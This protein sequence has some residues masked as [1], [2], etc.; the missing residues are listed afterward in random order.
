MT[1]R[2]RW[3]QYSV[4]AQGEATDGNGNGGVGTLAYSRATANVGD[5][6]TI[7]TYH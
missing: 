7:G 2:T 1:A 3:T 5:T 6:F 4:D